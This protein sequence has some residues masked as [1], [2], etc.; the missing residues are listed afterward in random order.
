M[1][2][3][4]F[5]FICFMLGLTNNIIA[6][7]AE[8]DSEPGTALE[9]DGND[10]YVS[11]AQTSSFTFDA[12]F[13]IEAWVKTHEMPSGGHTIAKKGDEWILRMYESSTF[14]ILEFGINNNAQFSQISLDPSDVIDQWVHMSAFVDRST[15]NESLQLF[16]NGEAGS[17]LNNPEAISGTADIHLC[18]DFKGIMDEFRI[19]TTARSAQEI[20]EN[21]HLTCSATATNLD[22]YIQFNDASGSTAVDVA[23]GNNGTLNNMNTTSCWANST[24][25]VGGGSS[26]TQTE[27]SGNIDF[28]GTGVSMDFSQYSGA[29]ITIT[30]LDRAPNLNPVLFDSQYWLIHRYGS[31][32][33]S[34]NLSFT[35]SEDITTEDASLP[36][37]IKLYKR[38]S[39]ADTY[40][41]FD[42]EANSAD[43]SENKAVF[44]N[45]SS[46]SQYAIC[47]RLPAEITSGHALNFDGENDD[48]Y[49]NGIPLN[50]TEISLEAWVNP[51]TLSSTVQRFLTIGSEVAV[52]RHDGTE[53][54]G[55]RELHFYIK[56]SNGSLYS[57]RV[58][59]TL[60]TNEWQHVCGTYDGTDMKLYLNGI[61]LST[62]SPNGGLY[63]PD[64]NVELNSSGEPMAGQMDE[65][66]VWNYA[67]SIEEIRA[68]MYQTLDGTERGLIAYFQ[69]NESS[70]TSATNLIGGNTATLH[71]MT[72]D[73]WVA[74]T[75]PVPYQSIADGDWGNNA[76]WQSGQNSPTND[77]TDVSIN[78]AINLDRS[79]TVGYLAIQSGGSLSIEPT[80]CLTVN[81][82][83]MN[84]EGA[85]GLVLKSDENGTASIIHNDTGIEATCQR[86]TSKDHWHYI[87]APVI[88]QIINDAWMSANNISIGTF[89][90][91]LFRWDEPT[92]YWILYGSDGDPVAFADETF[93]IG[94]GYAMTTTADVSLNFSGTLNTGNTDTVLTYTAGKGDGFHIIGNPFA[95]SIGITSDA[96]TEGNFINDNSGVLDASYQAIYI[97]Q[98]SD[99]N[100]YGDNEYAVI[101]NTDFSGEGG[102]GTLI[103]Q[104]YI[105]PGQAFMVKVG[106]PGTI[107]FNANTRIHQNATFYKSKERSPGIELKVHSE[108]ADNSCIIAFQPGMTKGLD[109]SYDA[110][111]V[112]GNSQQYVYTKL[113][114]D[115]G[116]NFAVQALPLY[117]TDAFI[118]PIGIDA[119]T[120]RGITFSIYQEKLDGA[121]I[122]LEDREKG[123]F[124][125]LLSK[126]Y[127]TT[128]K[129]SNANRFFLHLDHL[130]GISESPKESA[131]I[132]AWTTNSTLFVVSEKS[133]KQ[134]L[135]F[136]SIDGKRLINS[137]L[138]QGMNQIELSNF[139]RGIYILEINS[140]DGVSRKKIR[141]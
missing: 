141:Y 107:S 120:E 92:A 109:P 104:D 47:R 60:H 102:N 1:K 133:Q 21:M 32:T 137:P 100:S 124:T 113:V 95:C 116:F 96:T 75:A 43:A 50:L 110:A 103:D 70:G 108:T 93:T 80:S 81:D 140:T 36:E 132:Q 12:S 28:T 66:R 27:T 34:A 20:R 115:N 78:N 99:S 4:Y 5:I 130:T 77:W 54:G 25:P 122:K 58:D 51:A 23:G 44:N 106:A 118:I 56:Q 119:A 9:F 26:N 24:A 17:L 97:W 62:V 18:E 138:K 38:A 85:N 41:S 2:S 121:S 134:D 31:G 37:R 40:W 46:F 69:L 136:Y 83:L 79:D 52:L 6:Q 14:I 98:E 64:G 29:S 7:R 94:K 16:V 101:C 123:V 30:R 67:R 15:G 73:D 3:K 111:L 129:E 22:T 59:D 33:F 8:S 131:D 89:P 42:Q 57:I 39:N 53:D 91:Q 55:N 82:S 35:V 72:D 125:N 87:S 86:Y 105:A 112:R 68:D 74:S 71:N 127:T 10:D 49:G 88:G 11:L 61:L 117:S 90:Y 76:S 126:T 128:V 139:P 135:R 114:E 19:W 65:I 48:V 45:I 84:S 13:G 63:A